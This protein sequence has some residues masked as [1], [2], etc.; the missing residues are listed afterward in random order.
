MWYAD[1]QGMPAVAPLCDISTVFHFVDKPDP[2]PEN[3]VIGLSNQLFEVIAH[4]GFGLGL[5]PFV[6][7][8]V[9][10]SKA[11]AE[12]RVTGAH[13]GRPIQT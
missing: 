9:R 2:S 7:D 12:R 11:R 13:A 4:A 1:S 3:A 5:A 8:F 10:L 6:F